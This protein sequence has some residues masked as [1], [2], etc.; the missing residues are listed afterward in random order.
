MKGAVT[1]PLGPAF[2]AAPAGSATPVLRS[3]GE[4]AFGETPG[5]GAE[6]GESDLPSENFR[7][8]RVLYLQRETVSEMRN[9]REPIPALPFS[10]AVSPW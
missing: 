4:V 8:L 2:E 6:G 5:G 1:P 7:H 9:R 10:P 3:L